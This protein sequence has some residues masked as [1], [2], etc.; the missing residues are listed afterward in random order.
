VHY[1]D[2][3][4]SDA[5]GSE[6]IAAGHRLWLLWTSRHLSGSLR[7]LAESGPFSAIHDGV[8][9]AASGLILILMG[10]IGKSAPVSI[11]RAAPPESTEPCAARRAH[12]SIWTG[13]P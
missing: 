7:A 1:K 10:P 3:S 11:A 12:T 4:G 2:A 9:F 13:T 6:R 8:G 5:S